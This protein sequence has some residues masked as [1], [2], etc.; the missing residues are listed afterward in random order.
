MK[1]LPP[2][3]LLTLSAGLS[4]CTVFSPTATDARAL[5]QRCAHADLS[6]ATEEDRIANARCV[7]LDRVTDSVTGPVTILQPNATAFQVYLRKLGLSA[8][9]FLKDPRSDAF[10]R[11]HIA[12]GE[13]LSN[14]ILTTL[15]G[16]T[17]RVA[18]CDVQH[19]NCVV[20]GLRA[21]GSFPQL[22][23][24]NGWLYDLSG[25]LPME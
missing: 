13:K 4:G 9:E 10:A 6:Q 19:L 7:A 3:L 8:S 11:A 1:R 5:V 17:R 22:T 24:V 25:L 21:S 18:D 23:F 16:R 20:D 2:L 15:D 14:G 12:R